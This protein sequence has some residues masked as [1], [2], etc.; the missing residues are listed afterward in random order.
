MYCP[1]CGKEYNNVNYWRCPECGGPLAEMPHD[2][3]KQGL[4]IAALVCAILA[5][6]TFF[7]ILP[8]WIFAVIS[9]VLAVIQLARYKKQGL[10]IASIIISCLAVAITVG[11]IALILF[12][13]IDW[14]SGSSSYYEEYSEP[15]IEYELGEPKEL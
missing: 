3:G 2:E 5:L 13:R 7:I 1:N 12:T 9:I 15:G 14:S 6:L 4:G 8:T 11:Y 10:A